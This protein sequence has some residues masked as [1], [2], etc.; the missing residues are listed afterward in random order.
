LTRYATTSKPTKH[1]DDDSD[2]AR[3]RKLAELAGSRALGLPETATD[4][5][6]EAEIKAKE[7]NTPKLSVIPKGGVASPRRSGRAIE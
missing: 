3:C 5:F 4:L 2:D 1:S 7:T 6:T